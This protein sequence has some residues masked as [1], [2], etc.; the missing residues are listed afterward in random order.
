MAT[1]QCLS[2]HTANKIEMP[3]D[4]AVA[5]VSL[6]EKKTFARNEAFNFAIELKKRN[7]EL[8]VLFDDA[9]TLR[10]RDQELVAYAV[11]TYLRPGSAVT[12]HKI[13][14]VPGYRAKGIASELMRIL[15]ERLKTR[16]RSKVH[17]WVDDGNNVAREL[18]H[19]FGF[20]QNG[21]V[22]NYYAPGR[23][24]V[25]MILNISS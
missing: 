4:E 19:K 6:C 11:L 16:A 25:H 14:V 21:S 18:Y 23:T 10:P 24:G 20:E 13:C 2:T 12:L 17:L 7:L 1:V 9:N 3:R 22:P 8:F 5:K 15:I